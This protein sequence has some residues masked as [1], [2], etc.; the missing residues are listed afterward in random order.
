M[1]D[2]PAPP[3]S[4]RFTFPNFFPNPISTGVA[5]FLPPHPTPP[6]TGTRQA[7]K[8]SPTA[9]GPY[10]ALLGQ[11]IFIFGRLYI[12]LVIFFSSAPSCFLALMKVPHPSRSTLA[13]G[14]WCE[15]P[16]WERRWPTENKSNKDL[17]IILCKCPILRGIP[18]A[19]LR[20]ATLPSL[21]CSRQGSSLVDTGFGDGMQWTPMSPPYH[22]HPKILL[23]GCTSPPH[24]LPGI[25]LQHC[26]AP[27]NV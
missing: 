18:A 17:G 16:P 4:P 21:I 26:R 19:G 20:P 27:M 15:C 13:L 7:L 8:P 23:R 3:H 2:L 5:R 1:L 10:S 22:Q 9:P 14:L 24:P 12:V 11:K 6:L 25:A